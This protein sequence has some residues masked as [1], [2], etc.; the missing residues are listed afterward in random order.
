MLRFLLNSSTSKE[1]FVWHAGGRKYGLAIIYSPKPRYIRLASE[2]S[3]GERT[4]EFFQSDPSMNIN[5]TN[6]IH[7][8]HAEHISTVIFR[9]RANKKVTVKIVETATSR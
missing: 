9:Y 4:F 1:R 5:E 3:V 2:T 8:E 7:A 6:E